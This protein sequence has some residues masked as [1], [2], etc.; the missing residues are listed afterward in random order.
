M[1]V[2]DVAVR[3]FMEINLDLIVDNGVAQHPGGWEVRRYYRVGDWK[4]RTVVHRDHYETQNYARCDCF[5]W[6]RW[7]EVIAWSGNLLKDL[8][9]YQ[10]KDE[11]QIVEEASGVEWSMIHESLRMLLRNEEE[12]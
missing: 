3:K 4:F 7:S 10:S 1:K 6:G 11:S 2:D 9:G 8:P 12:E 5:T